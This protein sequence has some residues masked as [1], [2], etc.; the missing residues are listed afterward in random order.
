MDETKSDATYEGTK[1]GEVTHFF[2]KISVAVVNPEADFSVGDKV[3][4]YDKEGNVVV[5]QEIG[6]M[7]ID[8]EDQDTVPAGT[9]FGMKVE[10]EVREGYTIY[11]Q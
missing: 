11:K 10:G 9:E 2:D 5:E 7:Q 1:V 8:G 6:S 3:K 4:I